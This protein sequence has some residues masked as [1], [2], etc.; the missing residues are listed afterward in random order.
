M[1]QNMTNEEIREFNE[2]VKYNES[3][4]SWFVDLLSC[5]IAWPMIVLV[6]YRRCKY[7]TKIEI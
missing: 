1:K 5:M 7:N 3:G 4:F 2:K 6:I